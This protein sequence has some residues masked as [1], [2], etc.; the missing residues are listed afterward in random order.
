[1]SFAV[2]AA[3]AR[4]AEL[5]RCPACH[6]PLAPTQRS[7]ICARGHSYDVA[8]HGYVTLLRTDRRCPS[9]NDAAMVDARTAIMDTG[10]FEPLTAALAEKA[11]SLPL[12]DAAVI[13]DAGAGP[14]ITSPVCSPRCRKHSASRRMSARRVASRHS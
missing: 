7:L 13:L 14:D 6:G 12:P 4:V 9:G 11:N 5:L 3:L 10:F 1:M 2:P 8:R